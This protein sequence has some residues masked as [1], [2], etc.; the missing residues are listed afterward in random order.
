MNRVRKACLLTLLGLL[1]WACTVE[2]GDVGAPTSVPQDAPTVASSPPAL[3]Q[4]PPSSGQLDEVL[5]NQGREYEKANEYA[6]ARKAYFELIMKRPD[7]RFI[8]RAYLAF[9]DLFSSDARQ[10]PSKWTLAK[11]AYEKV[12]TYPPERN[13]V[14]GT[15][16]YKLGLVFWN[17][18]ELDHARAAFQKTIDYAAAYPEQP[19]AEALAE[20]A[21]NSLATIDA[22]TRPADAPSNASR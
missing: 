7:S 4:D 14:Y 10:D 3:A 17:S 8:P 12:I 2:T 5:Y 13:D 16:W 11:Q 9:G 19:R 6:K 15:A 20:S 21:R 1:P 18:G 22:L